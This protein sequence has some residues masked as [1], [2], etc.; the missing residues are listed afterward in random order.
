MD[1]FVYVVVHDRGFAPNPFFG[2]CTLATCKPQIRNQARVGDWI[3]GIGSRQKRQSG[4]LVYA[5]EVEE[6]LTY[7]EYW[8]DARFLRKRPNR[9]GSRKLLYGDNI[10]HRS[11]DTIGDWVQEDS[12]HS[13]VDGT[14]HLSHIRRD[15]GAPLVLISQ[16][17]VYLGDSAIPIPTRFLAWEDCDVF[18]QPIRNYRR[19]GYPPG[20][21]EQFI[22]WIDELP[23]GIVGE[24][25]DWPK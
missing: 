17:F 8:E 21:V 19:H 20:F 6:I 3:V 1:L 23:Q 15:T 11:A 10:Y 9:C 13:Q 4:K 12:A 25:S 7:E 5:M 24:P 2:C 18:T 14:P 16:R 22:A